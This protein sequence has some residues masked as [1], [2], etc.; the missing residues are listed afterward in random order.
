MTEELLF[1]SLLTPLAL[2]TPLSPRAAILITPLYFGIAHVHHFYEYHL[3][4]PYT[5]LTMELLR[6]AFQFTYT[7]VFGW[8]ANFI[9]VRT[10]SLPAVCLVHAFCN[11]MGLPR[12]WGRIEA[13][14]AAWKPV[15]RPRA[16]ERM[17]AERILWDEDPMG[18]EAGT[19]GGTKRLHVGWTVSYYVLLFAGVGA[20]AQE[21][22]PLTESSRRLAELR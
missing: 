2:L 16:K 12:L 17:K 10:G 22:W 8:Y 19:S 13:P 9:F 1:R 3:T 11:S 15:A 6:T 4:H 5:L 21:L 7:T 20:F 18:R 14:E